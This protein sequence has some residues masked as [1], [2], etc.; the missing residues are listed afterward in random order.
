ML[1]AEMTRVLIIKHAY[2][3]L[4]GWASVAFFL[5]CTVGSWSA[6]AR[7]QAPLFLIFVALGIYIL[8]GS[9]SM[10][11]DSDS[12][13]YYLPLRRYQIK[14]NEV[15]YIEIDRQ[16]SSMVFFGE[17]KKLAV[18]GPMYWS[19]INRF[20]VGRL[21]AAQIDRYGIEVRTTEKAIFRLSKNTKVTS[22]QLSRRESEF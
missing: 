7:L 13:R 3:K 1:S 9:G 18:I 16:G 21:I 10:Q 5:F 8:L 11:V 4:V 12:I 2:P 14:W 19:G 6:G 20:D 22:S 17:N 15:Q